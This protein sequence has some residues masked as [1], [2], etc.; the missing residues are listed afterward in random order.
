MGLLDG[1]VAVVTGGASGMGQATVLRFLEEGARV[2]VGDLN[3]E[4]GDATV[5]LARARG[6]GDRIRF[7]RTNVAEEDALTKRDRS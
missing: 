3:Q 4:T 1:K 7:I 2:V 5:E 6:A